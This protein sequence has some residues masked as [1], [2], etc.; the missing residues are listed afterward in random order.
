MMSFFLCVFETNI[1]LDNIKY[2]IC[3]ILYAKC[4]INLSISYSNSVYEMPLSF[5]L[6]RKTKI[7][8]MTLSENAHKLNGSKE[9]L[10]Q[11]LRAIQ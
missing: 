5:F 8:Y 3:I 2:I 6:F 10:N 11:Q 9:K 4:T 7:A 1:N